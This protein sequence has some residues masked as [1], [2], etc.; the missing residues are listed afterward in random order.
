[1]FLS[2]DTEIF[3]EWL[4]YLRS[5]NYSQLTIES[6]INSL[7]SLF[8]FFKVKGITESNY[9][10]EEIYS[11]IR[12]RL[13][14]NISRTTVQKDIVSI[15]QYFKFLFENS[16]I[17]E[18]TT[19]I[20]KLKS[21]GRKLPHIHSIEDMNESLN[22]PIRPNNP[23]YEKQFYRDLAIIETI[24]SSGLRREEIRTLEIKNI[25][26]GQKNIKVCGKG[27]KERII[28]IGNKALEAINNWLN[29][30]TQ[31]FQKNK[32]KTHDYVF[33]TT[34]G[35]ILSTSQISVRIKKFLSENQ[36]SGDKKPHSLRHTFAT[37]LLVSGVGIRDVQELLG[38]SSIKTT[39][40]YTHLDIKD[41]TK[42]YNNAHPRAVK[43]D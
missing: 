17:S 3:K 12:D 21:N 23:K 14:N 26:Y 33:T 1:M 5:L 29:I 30:R 31:I 9:S 19:D 11:F 15:K 40:V 27:N 37:H 43:Q 34:T 24:Y 20:I 16:Y 39:E 2:K 25:N 7:N 22:F 13:Q 35:D 18:N 32:E 38:H 28:P 6:Y 36:C 41:L 8:K 42:S 10:Q 4:I